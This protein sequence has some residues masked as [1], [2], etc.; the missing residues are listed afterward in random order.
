MSKI[1]ETKINRFD[2]GIV[3]DPRD[4]RKGVCRVSTNFDL[5]T[6]PYKITPYRNSESGDSASATSQKQNF[7]MALRT[8][9]IY[10]LYA[11]GVKSGTAIAEVMCKDPINTADDYTNATWQSPNNNQAALGA[12][13]FDLFVYYKYTTAANSRIFGAL[14]GTRIWSCDPTSVA[15]F[16][17][18]GHNL[19]YT[20][21]AQGLV[22]SKDD[23]LYIP[24]DNKIA[25]N[26]QGAWTDAALTLPSHLYITTIWE[27]G[28]YLMIACAPLSGIGNSV[29]YQWDRDSSLAT[30]SESIDGGEGI[31][32][33]GENI[34]GTNITISLSGGTSATFKD[35]VI[36]KYLSGNQLI[37]FR[38][39]VGTTSTLFPSVK[40]KK[41]NRLYFMMS[42]VLNGTRREGVWSIGKNSSGQLA[43][44]HERTPNNDTALTAGTSNLYNF[45]FVG[46]YLFQS[47]MTSSAYALSKTNNQESYEG[48]TAIYETKKYFAGDSSLK[49]K[50]IGVS[51]MTEPLPIAGQVVLKYRMDEETSY[52]PIMTEATDNSI[53]HSALNIESSG[54]NLPN[55]Y[56]EIDFRIESIGGAEVT[57]FKFKEE[58]IGKDIYD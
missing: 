52:T 19:T 17:D 27:N 11:L 53:S 57:C 37:Q 39:L 54:D 56:K 58:I 3:N 13:S 36:F 46:D 8:G 28:N 33:V 14:G 30:L 49:K 44:T 10:K 9:S 5:L 18:A 29:V 4:P 51:V 2:G 20:N 35:K 34:D 24:Y 48:Q 50:L 12:T 42:I 7:A 16:D 15:V 25:K 22:F 1:I 40:Q 21:I 6:N 26:N 43:V 23:I 31:I 32:K 38:E 41:G 45:I 47:Y 55:D